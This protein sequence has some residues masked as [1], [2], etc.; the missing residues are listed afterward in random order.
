M[1]KLLFMFCVGSVFLLIGS[2][3]PQLDSKPIFI[4][5]GTNST[6][7]I[8]GRQWVGDSAAD[9]LT[10]TSPGLIITS[11]TG[12]DHGPLY[13]TARIFN[14]TSNYTFSVAVS[15]T[16][17]V[18]LH[19]GALD[20]NNSLFGVTANNLRLLSQFNV[21]NALARANATSLVKEYAIRV[22][23]RALALELAP[24]TAASFAFVN[25]IEL[26]PVDDQFGLFAANSIDRALETMF[27]LN[28]G[29][30]R[31]SPGGDRGLFRD[32]EPDDRYMLIADA[33]S[34]VSNTSRVDYA[35]VNDT[36]AAP[37]EVYETARAM[38]DTE[39]LEKRFNMSWKFDVDPGGFEY[40]VR[41]HFC[42]LAFDRA[43]QRVFR[44]FV[45]NRTAAEGFDVFAR[46]GGK[47]KAYHVDYADAVETQ[48][49]TLW[50]QLGPEL[51]ASAAGTD[52][53]LNGLEVFKLGKNGNL[54][55]P[56]SRFGSGANSS[57]GRASK[58][59]VLYG[60]IASAVASAA[61]VVVVV[62]AVRGRRKKMVVAASAKWRSL[63]TVEASV[64]RAQ[65]A[66]A[67]NRT[68]GGRRFA[69]SEIRQATR[70][71][72]EALVIGT[73]G[74]GKVYKGE[75]EEGVAV[76]VKRA[77]P[78]SQQGVAEFETEIEMLS[79]LRHRHLV[80]MIGYCDEQGE[81]I[82]VYEYMSNGTLRG[83]LFGGPGGLGGG[84]ALDWKQRLE[85]CIGAAR[86]L[87]YLHTGAGD[88]GIIHRDVK[89]TNI[90]LDSEFVAKVADF[91]LSKAG[92]GW[93]Q[94]HVSTAVKGSFG[95]LDPEYFRLQQL[96]QKS[97][98]Y[99]FGVVLF[100]VV[101]ARPVI[102]PSLPKDQVNLAEWAVRWERQG[103]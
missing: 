48:I 25:A 30:P 17:F 97:D 85:A 71:F 93:D 20:V 70:N 26:V 53:I 78:Q 8:S 102:D 47:G 10:L 16:Y 54:A 22:T 37:L 77:H 40:L 12:A 28:V 101:C 44:I 58:S 82:L 62:G 38:S 98:V 99:S 41:L 21:S 76:A 89:T 68:M 75:I 96:T 86:G 66:F 90:L 5:C 79:K 95:Y 18:R 100:E 15:G 103:G 31:I 24:S 11:S 42:E 55:R 81:M 9:N 13:S 45:N 74:F 50:V 27:R 33:G 6:T 88:G 52:A 23:S 43:D 83:R 65:G 3:D 57:P 67:G 69:I 64:S 92:P 80:A 59:L 56:S 46:A 19:F 94:T 63:S 73:G 4:N 14:T 36:R 72:D 87:H 7:T 35:S 2:S 29:G 84:P 51:S 61:V 49:D 91:G 32:W 1:E 39:V 34:L 60:V